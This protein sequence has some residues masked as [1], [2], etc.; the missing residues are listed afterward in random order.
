[1]VSQSDAWVEQDDGD[2]ISEYTDVHTDVIMRLFIAIYS[3][4]M[5]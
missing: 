4:I 5:F 2:S 3:C 1:M